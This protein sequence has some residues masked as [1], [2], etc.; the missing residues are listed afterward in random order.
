MSELEHIAQLQA[1]CARLR[2]E[3]AELMAN[4]ESCKGNELA[5]ELDD[6]KQQHA[7]LQQRCAEV[8]AA[9]NDPIDYALRCQARLAQVEGALRDWQQWWRD[10]NPKGPFGPIYQRGEA[11]LQARTAS[12][13]DRWIMEKAAQEDGADVSAGSQARPASGGGACL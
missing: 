2:E 3:R 6:L 7:A 1:E 8:E 12:N 11:L 9:T 10:M 4:L 5:A 13:E